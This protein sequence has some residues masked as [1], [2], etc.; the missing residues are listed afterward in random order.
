[1]ADLAEG[2]LA[3]E[4]R[5]MARAITLVQSGGESAKDLLRVLRPRSGRA[6]V[7]GITGAA[8]AGKSTLVNRLVREFRARGRSVGVIAVDPTSALS[9]GA[10]LGDRVRMQDLAGD[11]GVF[12]RSMATR[13][14]LGG[15][16]RATED[17]VTVLDAAGKDV[18]VVETVGVGQDEIDVA[19]ATHTTVVVMVPGLGDDIQA[20]KAGV[21]EIA[22]IFVV[23]KADLD[24]AD[25]VALQLAGVPT[26]PEE[27]RVRPI[28]QTVARTGSGIT[29]L[30]D[31]ID[32]H[33]A[34][35][36][37]VGATRRVRNGLLRDRIL[38]LA[39]RELL[40]RLEARVGTAAIDALAA[41]VAR[42][43]VDAY[44]AADELVEGFPVSDPP[45]PPGHRG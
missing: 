32:S 20:M 10:V 29:E 30:A 28:I 8:G 27:E 15:L 36:A 45:A 16:A 5:A 6:H 31:A 4:P 43:E 41:R 39:G 11:P 38:A 37:T 21:L 22:D 44:Q 1:M 12:V 35:L 26:D 25:R 19:G 3:A 13:G 24:G 17:A 18:V 23:N 40:D 14:R 2:V 42:G 33:R 7:I 34:F 9:G